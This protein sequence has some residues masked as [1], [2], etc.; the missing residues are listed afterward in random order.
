ML[1]FFVIQKCVFH[2]THIVQGLSDVP[3]LGQGISVDIFVLHIS[4]WWNKFEPVQ[5]QFGKQH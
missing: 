5:H 4:N 1:S 3:S 2:S